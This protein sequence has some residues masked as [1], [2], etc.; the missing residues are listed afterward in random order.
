MKKVLVLITMLMLLSATCFA[1][2]YIEKA[3]GE[4]AAIGVKHNHNLLVD[5]N[6]NPSKYIGLGGA[7]TGISVWMDKTSI[8][9]HMYSPP[10]YI[11]EL[12]KIFY[13]VQPNMEKVGI[14]NVGAGSELE[15]FKYDFNQK[16]MYREIKYNNGKAA[17]EEISPKEYEGTSGGRSVIATGEIAFYLAYNMSFYERPMSTGL[18]YYL[19][20]GHWATFENLK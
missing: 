15:R 4:Y 13:S 11:I 20:H 9:V 12:K 14:M 3:D 17:W 10:I 18:Q 16:K 5:M 19:E 7:G 2:T 1:E 8:N 6:K